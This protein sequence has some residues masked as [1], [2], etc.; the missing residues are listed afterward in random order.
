MMTTGSVSREEM[1]LKLGIYSS[2]PNLDDLTERA[3]RDWEETQWREPAR[4]RTSFTASKVGGEP[5]CARQ[6]LYRLMNI[7][8]PEPIEPRGVAIMRQGIAAEDQIVFRWGRAG[9]TIA[10]SVPLNEGGR[11]RQLAIRSP[12]HWLAGFTDSVLDLRRI[13]WDY[14]TPVD[15]KS[16]SEKKIREMQDGNPPDDGE[17][18]T[19]VMIY[20]W[21]CIQ[22]HEQMGWADMGLK[23]AIGG[24]ILYV[25]RDNPRNSYE[26][27]VPY[28]ESYVQ[29]L[30]DDLLEWKAQFL[31]GRLPPRPKEWRWTEQPCK[32]CDFKKMC[33][34][35]IRDDVNVLYDSCTVKFA[36]EV[37]PG[38]DP[39]KNRRMVVKRWE[40]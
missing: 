38:Y 15:V 13:G 37:D 6:A 12:E 8:S 40:A 3:Y 16:K 10:G 26:V 14:V 28:E 29:E 19:Q 18:R 23:P 31:A 17:Y 2:G 22:I 35:D 30:L 39:E 5:R 20:T 7:P 24:S 21:G 27:W 32:W 33:K 4:P 11:I 9:L 34:Q 25:S 1:F 36:R